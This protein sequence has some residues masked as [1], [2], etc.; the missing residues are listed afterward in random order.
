MRLETNPLILRTVKESGVVHFFPLGANLQV[1][2]DVGVPIIIA[3]EESK[4]QVIDLQ[5]A[6]IVSN[7]TTQL[8]F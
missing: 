7:Y 3:I 5:I 8:R 6:N 1:M 4:K 2:P